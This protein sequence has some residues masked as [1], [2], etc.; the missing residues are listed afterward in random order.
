MSLVPLKALEGV[1]AV[2]ADGNKEYA[3]WSWRDHGPECVQ[4][5]LN[6]ALR[7]LAQIESNPLA[8]DGKSGLPAIDHAIASLLIARWHTMQVPQTLSAAGPVEYQPGPVSWVQQSFPF[9]APPWV[10][11]KDTQ[12]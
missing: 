9:A 6:A 1:A 5:Y 4:E 7:H 10:A 12:R 11:P 2:M 8:M 3:P